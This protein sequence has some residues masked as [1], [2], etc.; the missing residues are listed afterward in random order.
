MV[1]IKCVSKMKYKL[2][3]LVGKAKSHSSLDY[4]VILDNAGY[5]TFII[6]NFFNI[7]QVH[8]VS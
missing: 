3:H 4:A 6:V 5:I 2:F 8:L 1:Y 7:Y